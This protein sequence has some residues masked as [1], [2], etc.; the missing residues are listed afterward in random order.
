MIRTRGTA[1][2]VAVIAGEFADGPDAMLWNPYLSRARWRRAALRAALRPNVAVGAVSGAGF[3]VVGGGWASGFGIVLAIGI[4][5]LLLGSAAFVAWVNLESF[6]FDHV[7]PRGRPCRL[8]QRIGEYFYR[9][10]DFTDLGTTVHATV[11]AMVEAVAQLHRT[12]SRAWLDPGLCGEAHRVVWEVLC[13]LDRTRTA[14]ILA[15]QLHADPDSGALAAA[16]DE[17]VAVVDRALGEVLTHLRNCV[18]LTR[19]W[20][21]KL[22][23]DD[24]RARAEDILAALSEIRPSRLVAAAEPLPQRVFAYLTAARDV[25]GTGPFPWEQHPGPAPSPASTDGIGDATDRTAR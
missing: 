22:H 25:T 6:A 11:A 4:G 21:A 13:S 23:H 15:R 2:A 5:V 20:E 1:L 9:A 14:R 12:P 18:A 8:E 3:L 17:A 10:Q 16:V 24:L 19:A 7:H